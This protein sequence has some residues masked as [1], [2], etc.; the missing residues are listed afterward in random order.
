MW[1]LAIVAILLGGN[2]IN[3][4]VTV[5]QTCAHQKILSNTY[6][7]TGVLTL[8]ILN[9]KLEKKRKS[10]GKVKGKRPI[11]KLRKRCEV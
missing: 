1:L 10:Q 4:E 2:G 5:T 3:G 7:A 6:S 9:C 11:Q 8:D